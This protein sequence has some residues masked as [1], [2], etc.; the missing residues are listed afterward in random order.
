MHQIIE[1]LSAFQDSWAK[2]NDWSGTPFTMSQPGGMAGTQPVVLP[3]IDAPGNLPVGMGLWSALG[4]LLDSF[5]YLRVLR[6]YGVLPDDLKADFDWLATRHESEPI[7]DAAANMAR[8]TGRLQFFDG[9]QIEIT[10]LLPGSAPQTLRREA[11]DLEGITRHLTSLAADIATGLGHEMDSGLADRIPEPEAS[12]QELAEFYAMLFQ[13]ELHLHLSLFGWPWEDER[14]QAD[15]RALA[16][17]PRSSRFGFG[18]WCVASAYKRAMLPASA[19]IGDLLVAEAVAFAQRYP[20]TPAPELIASA[21]YHQGYTEEAIDLLETVAELTRKPAA[22]T[23]MWS[24]YLLRLGQLSDALAVCQRAIEDGH[25]DAALYSQYAAQMNYALRAKAYPI[26]LVFSEGSPT[27][28]RAVVNEVLAGYQMAIQLEPNHPLAHE[29]LANTLLEQNSD[30]FW[31]AFAGLARADRSGLRTREVLENARSLD[32]LEP[33]IAILEQALD[34]YP[35]QP[36][37]LVNLAMAFLY[38]EEHAQAVPLLEQARSLAPNSG[39][40]ADIQV[41]L[42]AANDPDFEF[43]YGEIV[44]AVASERPVDDETLSYLEAVLVDAPNFVD[45]CLLLADAYLVVSEHDS[46]LEVLLDALEHNPHDPAISDKVAE[47]LMDGGELQLALSYVVA[48]RQQH[49]DDVALIAREG[50][51][52][53]LLGNHQEARRLL[54]LAERINPRHPALSNAIRTIGRTSPP[55]PSV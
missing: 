46:A 35:D 18:A 54:S 15:W 3:P 13:W 9:V 31:D 52:N 48:S 24:R 44:E 29:G 25:K 10:L 36:D 6:T 32:E 16:D 30:G 19:V 37:H 26:R 12:P 17:L 23:I 34:L 53:Y 50:L 11:T 1:T 22:F 45:A 55:D 33:A 8:I 42:L 5:P 2:R 27:K 39:I 14:I 21:L 40:A 51:L 20:T 28:D 47:I 38:N 49:G 4:Y 7:A 41:H 43:R